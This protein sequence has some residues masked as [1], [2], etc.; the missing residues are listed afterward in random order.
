MIKH[1]SIPIILVF[2][3]FAFISC[4]KGP[5]PKMSN[6]KYCIAVIEVLQ[7]TNS[8]SPVPTN[9]DQFMAEGPI[10]TGNDIILFSKKRKERIRWIYSCC[11]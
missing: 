11:I 8:F 10:L 5:L 7:E 4:K 3:M 9:E 1:I 6:S 2:T